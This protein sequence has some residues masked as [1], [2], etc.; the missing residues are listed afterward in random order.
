MNI[1]LLVGVIACICLAG[2]LDYNE[3]VVYN[4]SNATYAAI[5]EE[6]GDVSESEIVDAYMA[7][8]ARW[9]SIGFERWLSGED[10]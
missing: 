8:K 10:E 4:M 9:D 7:D 2:R 5:K 1:I 6:L 3:E